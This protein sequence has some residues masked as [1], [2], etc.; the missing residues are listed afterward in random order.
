MSLRVRS[1]SIKPLIAGAAALVALA[2]LV[3]DSGPTNAQDATYMPA[4]TSEKMLKI[5]EAKIWRERPYFGSLVALNALNDGNAPFP[6]HHV[7]YVD[8][9]SS[10]HYKKSG[11]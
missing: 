7:V 6:E 5:P 2:A 10:A 1:R 11:A 3:S 4:F 9:V 8:P